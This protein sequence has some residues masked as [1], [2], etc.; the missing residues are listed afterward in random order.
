MQEW[1][2]WTE[3]M[4]RREGEAA[5]LVTSAA[6]VVLSVVLLALAAEIGRAQ[7]SARDLDDLTAQ[8]RERL[9][10]RLE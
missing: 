7:I 2:V 3:A 6:T 1:D 8:V 4:R 5:V 9:A 10:G